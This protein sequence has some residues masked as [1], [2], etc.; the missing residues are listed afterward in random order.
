MSLSVIV[1]IFCNLPHTLNPPSS[2][3]KTSG[4]SFQHI[5]HSRHTC[6]TDKISFYHIFISYLKK[7]IR[8]VNLSL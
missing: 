5:N 6:D 3:I 2:T 8:I 1:L 4:E 7:D